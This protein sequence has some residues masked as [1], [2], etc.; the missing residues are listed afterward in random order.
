MVLSDKELGIC[1]FFSEIERGVTWFVQEFV[2]YQGSVVS[3]IW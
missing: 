1:Y 2:L 3:D